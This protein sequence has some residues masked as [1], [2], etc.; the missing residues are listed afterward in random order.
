MDKIDGRQ[1]IGSI[2]Q[3]TQETAESLY[4]SLLSII[5]EEISDVEG[6]ENACYRVLR[7]TSASG[8]MYWA[9]ILRGYVIGR[10]NKGSMDGERIYRVIL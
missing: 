7:I 3:C 4:N 5:G 6:V 9:R 10:V 1:K 2:L 8:E